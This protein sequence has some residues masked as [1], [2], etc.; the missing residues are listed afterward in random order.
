MSVFCFKNMKFNDRKGKTFLSTEV[1]SESGN[2]EKVITNNSR[3]KID[4]F[5]RL[6]MDQKNH[7]KF[8]GKKG[9]RKSYQSF[10]IQNGFGCV[11][12]PLEGES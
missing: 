5:K 3:N 10:G 2:Y 12:K 9:R 6:K 11:S 4:D 7:F 8:K 1:I